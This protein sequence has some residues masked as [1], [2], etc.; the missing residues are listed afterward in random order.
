MKAEF[1]PAGDKALVVRLGQEISPETNNQVHALAES[2]DKYPLYGVLEWTP[3]Y[4]ELLI[5]YDPGVMPGPELMD[6]IE[7]RL[8]IRSVNHSTHFRT[9]LVPVF[10][11]GE[12][13]PDLDELARHT[14]LTP[15]EVIHR[16]TAPIYRIYMLGFSPGFCYL[17]GL[18][19]SLTT[20]RRKEPRLRTPA[21]SVGIAESQTGIYPIESP[22]GWQLI[23]RTP[24]P[25]FTP[26]QAPFFLF[27]AGSCLRF[28]AIGED[29]Y[30]EI[31][32]Q[33]RD[34]TYTL[35]EIEEPRT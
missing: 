14:G 27:S 11:G 29:E 16:H 35:P 18:D 26:N 3:S 33:V 10:Y 1:Y 9:R 13:G 8:P 30:H 7:R 12:G 15:A 20:P 31:V 25:L 19:P 28:R 23:G 21:G 5:E 4:T 17:G 34:R 6:C 2:L 24:V 32:K 22:G